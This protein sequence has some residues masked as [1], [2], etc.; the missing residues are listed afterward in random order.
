VIGAYG[1]TELVVIYLWVPL[2]AYFLGRDWELAGLL[3]WVAFVA[4]AWTP[5]IL[6]WFPLSGFATL[7]GIGWGGLGAVTLM[8]V[9]LFLDG[10]VGY[11]LGK[12]A[13][14]RDSLA[15]RA[16]LEAGP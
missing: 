6:G 7:G 2:W 12:L 4:Y 10:Y 13:F 14:V 8:C 5:F 16:A 15:L 3:S 1:P 9:T 11:R